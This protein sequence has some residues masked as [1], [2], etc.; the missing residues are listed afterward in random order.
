M[1]T[2]TL[3]NTGTQLD[4][5]TIATGK[6]RNDKG[7]LIPFKAF[8]PDNF[9]E[10]GKAE[11]KGIRA[12]YDRARTAYWAENKAM[13]AAIVANGGV[14]VRSVKVRTSKSGVVGFTITGGEPPKAKAASVSKDAE[15][16]ALKAKLAALE[17][18]A[19]TVD[20]PAS[21]A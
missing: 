2:L 3:K 7:S 14:I 19:A 16:A 1:N 4:L 21:E 11:K 13:S 17:A 15:I 12:E 5:P 18:K 8:A 9:A 10:L 20:V 6:Y